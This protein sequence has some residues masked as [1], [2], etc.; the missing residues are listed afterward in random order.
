[1]WSIEKTA[2]HIDD[3][4]FFEFEDEYSGEI[5]YIFLVFLPL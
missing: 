4:I 1:M 3:Q 5:L 2:Q